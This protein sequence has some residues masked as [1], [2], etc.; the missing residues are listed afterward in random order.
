MKLSATLLT[1]T[2]VDAAFTDEH[3]RLSLGGQ[4]GTQIVDEHGNIVQL[5]GISTFNPPWF[6]NCGQKDAFCYMSDTLGATMVRIAMDADNQHWDWVDQATSCGLYVLIDYHYV[7]ARPIADD[8][9]K[10][11]FRTAAQKYSSQKNVMY[12]LFNEPADMPWGDIKSYHEAM[13]SVIRPI[14]PEAIIVCGTP[15][16]SGRPGDVVGNT[17]DGKNIMYTKHFYAASHHDESDIGNLATQIPI[18]VTEWGVCD[19]SGDGN[20]DYDSAVRWQNMMDGGNPA[21]VWLSW[22]NWGWNDK[23]ESCSYMNPGSCDAHNWGSHSASG[24]HVDG[25]LK[26]PGPPQGPP[27]PPTPPAPTPIGQC[28]VDHGQ[29]NNGV[30]LEASARQTGDMDECCTLC[31][32][33]DGC[34]GYTH[35]TASGE[36]W[37]KSSLGALTA[38]PDVNS[39]GFT[40]PAPTPPPTPLTPPAPTPPAPTPPAPTPPAPTPPAPPSDCPGGSLAAC[41]QQCPSGAA[42]Q[43][44]VAV[45]EE[46]CA[47]PQCG[48][49]DGDS[50]SHCVA[51]CPSASFVD[52]IGC[53]EDKFPSIVL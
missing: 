52:C 41:I 34:Q 18:F 22:I 9:A 45:C 43:V 17:I 51:N 6:A 2:V 20:L 38:D 4:Y 53:C 33:A 23:G 19:Y 46:R 31:K 13:I 35:V 32:D 11:F 12:E 48:D 47:S 29:N 44:C 7:G 1:L 3:G 26:R 36:C 8:N 49:D 40:R 25:Y 16:W 15:A 50:L 14:D 5:R 37:L 42:F 10:N 28:T 30:N 24:S 21:G 27:S 39:G